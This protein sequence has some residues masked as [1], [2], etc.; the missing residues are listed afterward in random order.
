VVQIN[1]RNYLMVTTTKNLAPQNSRLV[2]AEPEHG[3]WQTVA[4]SRRDGSYQ[5]GSQTQISGY[6]DPIP[7]P[8]RRPGG[9]TSWPTASPA[10]IRWC[11]IGPRRKRSPTGDI[12]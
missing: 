4:G 5:D 3:G 2:A 9:C 1:R 6:D 10:G 8:I 12:I 11:C 7:P